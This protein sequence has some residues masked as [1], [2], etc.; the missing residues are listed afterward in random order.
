MP[1][2]VVSFPKERWRKVNVSKFLKKFKSVPASKIVEVPE[3]E[4]DR[5]V[6]ILRR[7]KCEVQIVEPVK[8]DI[9]IKILKDLLKK[10][11][12]VRLGIAEPKEL[13]KFA[14]EVIEKFS[15]KNLSDEVAEIIHDCIDFSENPIISELNEMEKRVKELLKK[16]L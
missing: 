15:L 11:E 6:E 16:L 10:I 2:V 8:D 4:L 9:E 1:L 5:V 13:E 7:N 3:E 12:A 14:V